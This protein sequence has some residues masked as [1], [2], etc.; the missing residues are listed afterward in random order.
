[1]TKPFGSYSGATNF[2]KVL[3]TGGE[4]DVIHYPRGKLTVSSAIGLRTPGNGK[5]PLRQ[6]QR[7]IKR[8]RIGLEL[9]LL[10]TLMGCVGVGYVDGGY[11]G[12][13]V[14][15]EPGVVLFDG[16]YE[17]GRDVHAYSHRGA[18]SRGAAHPG[19]GARGA[20]R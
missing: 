15:P 1:M 18:E 9:G 14:V 3:A 12:V 10:T 8:I 19:G 7:P 11:E 17:R 13:A 2:G 6:A 16:G 20:R 4:T 5:I